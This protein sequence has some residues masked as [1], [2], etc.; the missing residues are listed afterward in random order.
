MTSSRLHL[1]YTDQNTK[2]LVYYYT[3]FH[4][5]SSEE[6]TSA[7]MQRW[8][9]RLHTQAILL[10]WYSDQNTVL[11]LQEPAGWPSTPSAVSYEDLP[12]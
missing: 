7:V 1:R 11:H 12:A 8:S 10:Q 4:A 2:G 5:R 9:V 3:V 6:A